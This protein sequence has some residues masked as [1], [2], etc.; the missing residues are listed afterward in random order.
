MPDN[1]NAE[2][3]LAQT[4]SWNQDYRRAEQGYRKVLI[5]QPDHFDARLGLAQTLAWQEVYDAALQEFKLLHTQYPEHPEILRGIGLVYFW[6]HEYRRAAEFLERA[7]AVDPNSTDAHL[8]LA[9]TYYGLQD[10]KRAHEQYQVVISL[11]PDHGR[12]LDQLK[13]TRALTLTNQV[14]LYGYLERFSHDDRDPHY[15]LT[16]QYQRQL[17]RSVRLNGTLGFS[18]KKYGNEPYEDGFVGMGVTIQV[19]PRSVF[20]AGFNL[21]PGADVIPRLDFVSE[22]SQSALAR[23]EL[24]I[25]YRRMDF[26]E[27]AVNIVSPGLAYYFSDRTWAMLRM[28]GAFS[29]GAERTDAVF[30]RFAYSL[31][32]VVVVWAGLVEGNE[33]VRGLSLDNLRNLSS[34]AYLIHA[35]YSVGGDITLLLD[36]QYLVRRG[37]FTEHA[38]GLGV[39]YRW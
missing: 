14:D 26:D 12:A 37:L 35:D 30:G 8:N 38:F 9:D 31:S 15:S 22:F 33:A 27:V 20:S 39:R 25:A 17:N 3:L 28:Y 2:F 7:V 18:R 13:R 11:V 16:A 4:L 1:I 23:T 32:D 24:L 21:A 36:Y 6:T 10:W 34:R 29:E 5:R 19:A